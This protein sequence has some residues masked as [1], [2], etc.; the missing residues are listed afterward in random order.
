MIHSPSFKDAVF[1]AA[2]RKSGAGGLAELQAPAT[3]TSARSEGGGKK[4]HSHKPLP[5]G[6]QRDGFTYRQIACDGEAALYEQSWGGCADPSLCYEVIRIRKREGFQIGNRFIEPAE[7]YP[8]AEAWGV[9]GRTVLSRDG[10][11]EKL[12]EFSS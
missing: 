12:R 9:D 7:V 1:G 2:K 10:A 4:G 6:F 11:F 8:N 5:R 3:K